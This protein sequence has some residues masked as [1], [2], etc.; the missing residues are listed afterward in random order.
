MKQ[1]HNPFRCQGLASKKNNFKQKHF[2]GMKL[3]NQY[4]FVKVPYAALTTFYVFVLFA[5]L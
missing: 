2:S 4:S 5:I 3:V 1:T